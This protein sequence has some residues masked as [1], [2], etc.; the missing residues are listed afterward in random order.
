MKIK[1]ALVIIFIIA[2]I[3]PSMGQQEKHE[4]KG[5]GYTLLQH[6]SVEPFSE[7]SIRDNL[8]LYITQGDTMPLTIDADDN[9]FNYIITEVKGEQLD[10][11]IADTVTLKHGK[12]SGV[13]LS[14]P[15]FK[16]LVADNGARAAGSKVLHGQDLILTAR[17][18]A[19]IELNLNYQTLHIECDALSH[20]H[21]RGHVNTIYIKQ[22]SEP[23]IK[24]DKLNIDSRNSY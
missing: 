17:N 12:G 22:G 18:G 13:F 10:I 11:H 19:F 2:V 16:A 9:L 7:I 23:Y 21:L 1:T 6:R 24:I 20:I 5:N 15:E 8:S 3:T 14:I 4:I